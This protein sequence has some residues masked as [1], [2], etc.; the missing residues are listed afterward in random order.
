MWITDSALFCWAAHFILWSSSHCKMQKQLKENLSSLPTRPSALS[1]WLDMGPHLNLTGKTSPKLCYHHCIKPG[2]W[3]RSWYNALLFHSAEFR[4]WRHIMN[5][6]FCL[7]NATTAW[8]EKLCKRPRRCNWSFCGPFFHLL[9]RPLQTWVNTSPA[10]ITGP[11]L[12]K[13]DVL[14]LSWPQLG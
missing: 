13:G 4:G 1:C 10:A 7:P 6:Y 14:Q 9:A 12:H 8:E 11:C 3:K 2:N 5:V